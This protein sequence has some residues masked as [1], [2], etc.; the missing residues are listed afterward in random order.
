MRLLIVRFLQ[1]VLDVHDFMNGEM[2]VKV[3]GERE[4]AVE[5]RLDDNRSFK[6]CFSLP[7]NTDMEA[8]TS[9]MSADGILTITAPRKVGSMLFSKCSFVP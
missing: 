4:L 3:V 9:V 1:I 2:K 7:Q 8:I 5:G 6:R